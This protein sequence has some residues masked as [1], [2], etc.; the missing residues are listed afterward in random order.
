MEINL[1][2]ILEAGE[3]KTNM[4]ASWCGRKARGCHVQ[5]LNTGQR[6][7]HMGCDARFFFFVY[8]F[9]FTVLGS[10]SDFLQR[11][12]ADNMA[13]LF[14]SAPSSLPRLLCLL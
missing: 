11:A 2:A 3:L 1:F 10:C 13:R 12:Q 6:P 14:G 8:L 4:L 9:V 5:P 7:T